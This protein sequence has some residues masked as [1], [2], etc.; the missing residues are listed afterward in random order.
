[1]NLQFALESYRQAG[2][3]SEVETASRFRL[4]QILMEHTLKQ[5]AVACAITDGGD[6]VKRREALGKAIDGVETLRQSLSEDH[7]DEELGQRLD[8][9]Y[10]HMT[11]ELVR[12]NLDMSPGRIQHVQTLLSTLKSAWDQLPANRPNDVNLDAYFS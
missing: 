5:L 4:I 11:E 2:P 6:A 12:S 1:M 3:V 10:S 8:A 7:Q 9:L